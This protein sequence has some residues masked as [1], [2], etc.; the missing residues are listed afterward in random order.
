M[1]QTTLCRAVKDEAYQFFI[2][3]KFIYS[4]LIMF[5]VAGIV[6]IYLGSLGYKRSLK[7]K[8][9]FIETEVSRIK[10]YT[11]KGED[12]L[13]GFPVIY[14]PS[15]MSFLFEFFPPRVY[16]PVIKS[17]LIPVFWEFEFIDSL[18]S[19][20][21]GLF[22]LGVYIFISFHMLF[23]GIFGDEGR[24]KR[25]KTFTYSMRDA[26][27]R[28]LLAD[29]LLI[30]AFVLLYLIT[31]L[32]G[33]RLFGP[34]SRLLLIFTLYTL[35]FANFF[36]AL[37]NFIRLFFRNSDGPFSG[38]LLLVALT[39]LF[40][41][42]L[43]VLVEDSP[44]YTPHK[45]IEKREKKEMQI[46]YL[47]AGL[48]LDAADGKRTEKDRAMADLLIK[49]FLEFIEWEQEFIDTARKIDRKRTKYAVLCPTTFFNHLSNEISG[50]SNRGYLDFYQHNLQLKKKLIEFYI[51][52]KSEPFMQTATHGSENGKGIP[53]GPL[54]RF[55]EPG[56]LIYEARGR[57]PHSF[58]WGLGVTLVYTI[59]L[60]L[61]FHL[62][63]LVRPTCKVVTRGAMEDFF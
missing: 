18:L 9:N 61:L 12:H 42:L 34:G 23:V 43:S 44:T 36:Y 8:N 22:T 19:K 29:I 49:R 63:I 6:L 52:E 51:R 47:S 2:K 57:L 33:F 31:G 48:D 17:R 40:P 14:V 11:L 62:F 59:I 50:N 21:K 20:M 7:Y 46:N 35:V 55:M 13:E 1:D 15:Q 5:M 4:T 45:S 54:E 25:G 10:E 38:L 60:F 41:G 56:M 53:K 58:F 26:I 39:I 16:A 28:M 27:I 24:K 32:F 37:G 30:A 3:N